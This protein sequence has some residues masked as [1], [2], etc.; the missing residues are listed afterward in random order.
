MRLVPESQIIELSTHSP[1]GNK[2]TNK[3]NHSNLLNSALS[4]KSFQ[5][6]PYVLLNILAD[7]I[8]RQVVGIGAERVFDL[9]GN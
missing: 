8:Y 7:L 3:T 6:F 4:K 2:Q 5:D 1:Q 9:F